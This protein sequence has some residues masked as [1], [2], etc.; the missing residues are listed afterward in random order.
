MRRPEPHR[1]VDRL[2]VG[3]LIEARSCERFVLL[4]D[5]LPDA[6]LKE[7]YGSLYESEAR[8]HATYVRLARD[9][10]SDSEVNTRLQELAIAEAAIM[11]EGCELPRVHS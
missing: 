1:V 4:R 10:A 2:L 6:Q 9:F 8:H 5:H 7:F 3:A 11:A